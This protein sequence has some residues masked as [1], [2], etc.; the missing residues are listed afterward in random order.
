[1]NLHQDKAEVCIRYKGGETNAWT[2]TK[3]G[4]IS[5]NGHFSILSVR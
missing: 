4:E 3:G 5:T 2:Q 1:V